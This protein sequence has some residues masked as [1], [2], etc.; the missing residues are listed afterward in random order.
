MTPHPPIPKRKEGKKEGR[1]KLLKKQK[2]ETECL[3]R[4]SI[5]VC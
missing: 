4:V 1:Q 5:L 3:N 2:F